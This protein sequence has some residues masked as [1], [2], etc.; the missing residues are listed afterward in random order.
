MEVCPP[1][2]VWREVAAI[3]GVHDL[4]SAR[5]EVLRLS[6]VPLLML[7]KYV[8]DVESIG[9]VYVMVVSLAMGLP[10]VDVVYQRYCPLTPPEAVRSTVADGAHPDPGVAR[11]AAG[12]AMTVAMTGVRVLSQVPLLMAT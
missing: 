3:T 11:G 10:P 5:M 4:I 6:Q 8:V 12:N 1:T 9:V 7:T 2:C